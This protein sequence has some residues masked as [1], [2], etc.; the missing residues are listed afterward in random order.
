MSAKNPEP[1]RLRD[2]RAF[3]KKVQANWK[4]EAEGD[5]RTEMTV[6]KAASIRPCPCQG[7]LSRTAAFV[8]IVDSRLGRSVH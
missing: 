3:H 2:G 1:K 4:A 8:Q 6:R 7:A 5:V